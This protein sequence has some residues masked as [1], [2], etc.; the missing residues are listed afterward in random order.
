[1]SF[2]YIKGIYSIYSIWKIETELTLL[3]L[4]LID[5]TKIQLNEII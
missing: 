5:E 1:M 2:Y 3:K 4:K